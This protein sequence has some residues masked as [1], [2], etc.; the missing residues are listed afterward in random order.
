MNTTI[1][2]GDRV[3]HATE[4]RS[5]YVLAEYTDKNGFNYAVVDWDKRLDLPE[6]ILSSMLELEKVGVKN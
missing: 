6:I 1:I 2:P 3:T 4:H 5:G